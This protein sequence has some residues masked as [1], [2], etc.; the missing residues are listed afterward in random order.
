[1]SYGRGSAFREAGI[2]MLAFRVE[3]TGRIPRPVLAR[4]EPGPS[5][6]AAALKGARDVYFPSRDF[7]STEVYDMEKLR[8]GNGLRGPA[9]IETPVTTI[10]LHPGQE[11]RVDE[12]L[13]VVIEG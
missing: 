13:N 4:Q 9:I 11:A 1:M 7:V 2:E 3:A 10:V 12:Y 5:N 8:A 6:P